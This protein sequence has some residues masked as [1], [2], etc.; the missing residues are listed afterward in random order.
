M[1][2]QVVLVHDDKSFLEEVAAAFAAR[3]YDIAAFE[4]AITAVSALE[5]AERADVLMTRLTFPPGNPNGVSLARIARLRRPGI[6]VFFTGPAQLREYTE[7]LGEF[8]PNPISVSELVETVARLLAEQKQPAVDPQREKKG[9]E[10]A[11]I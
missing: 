6:K 8:L 1:P 2:A 3:G 9:R 11:N 10:D 4:R 5:A 7:G